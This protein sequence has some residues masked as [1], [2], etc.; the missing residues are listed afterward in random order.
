MDAIPAARFVARY[1]GRA[2]DGGSVGMA[3]AIPMIKLKKED[4]VR[5]F[6]VS[7]SQRSY[8]GGKRETGPHDAAML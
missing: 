3:S 8:R 2:S 1:F 4:L 6:P 5:V 7:V